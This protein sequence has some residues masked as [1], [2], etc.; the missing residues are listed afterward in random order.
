MAG[1]ELRAGLRGIDDERPNVRA[2]VDADQRHFAT[3]GA[4][5]GIHPL[6]RPG[7]RLLD[8]RTRAAVRLTEPVG[9]GRCGD[10]V[11]GT[12]T[13]HHR[14]AVIR[15][16]RVPSAM[17]EQQ[18]Y[19]PR[20]AQFTPTPSVPATGAA[21]VTRSARSHANRVAMKPPA[22]IP[23]TKTRPG[24]IPY[25]LDSLDQSERKPTSSTPVGREWR[26]PR[27]SAQLMSMPSG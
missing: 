7:R 20:G 22:D 25:S 15:N 23:V 21:A 19:R 14:T 27:P 12:A 26:A 10:D 16:Y 6:N 2:A 1:E 13:A 17:G 9:Q 4:T 18:R 3:A 8:E 5:G 24:G 11:A